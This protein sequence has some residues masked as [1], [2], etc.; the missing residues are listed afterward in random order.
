VLDSKLALAA[1]IKPPK[2][3]LSYKMAQVGLPRAVSVIE[4]TRE[5]LLQGLSNQD[6]GDVLE[7]IDKAY[8]ENGLGTLAISGIP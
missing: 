7:I 1:D 5:K 6:N 2:R 8:S 3:S 4:V